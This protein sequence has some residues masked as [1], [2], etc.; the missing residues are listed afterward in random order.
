MQKKII[1]HIT[2]ILVNILNFIFAS[3]T[4]GLTAIA[5]FKPEWIEL[6]I[7]WMGKQVNML[8]NW[9]YLIAL[10]SSIIE[11][12]PVIGVLVPGQQIMLLVGG[13]FGKN[14]LIEVIIVAIIGA[15][16]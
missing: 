6:F 1:H 4:I 12:F 15:I 13:F 16:A 5:L 9:N 7:E 10:T 8:G 2:K 11:S 3:I 14:A